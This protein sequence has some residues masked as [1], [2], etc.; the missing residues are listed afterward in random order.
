[1]QLKY[2]SDFC[3]SL[4]LNFINNIQPYGFLLVLDR[5]D[6]TI[7]QVSQNVGHHLGVPH[8][9]LVEQPLSSIVDEHQVAELEQKF[10]SGI[11]EK[12]PFTL[13][14]TVGGQRRQF[15]CLIHPKEELLL[16]EAEPQANEGAANHSFIAIYQ[17]VKFLMA[18]VERATTLQEV[19][20]I[21]L[22][23][24][25]RLSGFDRIMVYRFD[26]QWNGLVV[27][28]MLE[29]GMEPYLGLR[30]PASDIPQQAR[31]LY[32]KNAYRLIPD[33]NYEPVK[34]YPVI[35]PVLQTFADLSDCNLRAVATVHL[36]YL[37]N[38]GVTA[39]MSVR[40]IVNDE[41]WGLISC[42]HRTAKFLS[43][44]MC[45]V[46]ELLSGVISAKISSLQKQQDLG[47]RGAL[48]EIQ[49]ELVEQL[50][51]NGLVK[52]LTAG[53][54]NILSLLSADGVAIIQN[55]TV[56]TVGQT[57]DTHFLHDLIFW[58]QTKGISRV[59]ATDS[60]SEVYDDG[61]QHNEIASGMIVLPLNA[62]KG[63]FIIAFRPEVI[64]KFDWG[65]NPNERIQFE[66]D[67]K[68][69]HPRNSFKLWQQTVKHT[70]LPWHKEEVAIAEN[71]RH[72]LVEY[73]MKKAYV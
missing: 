71:L 57:P 53:S 16:I 17:Q 27:A 63:E 61:Y 68:T 23:E 73:T 41:L 37:G 29:E 35:N 69:Y 58:L 19:C 70:S 49:S 8:T 31:A 62:E 47:R 72:I 32:K 45:S 66:K 26:E 15:L 52:A 38:M 1:M 6:L 48:R 60:I 64:Q 44:E 12:L 67:N 14:F 43:Y 13:A 9:D 20:D 3:G 40:I 51:S 18:S 30:F 42:H 36:E 2:D 65:G 59:F 56:E 39:S 21:T 46:F 22:T 11:E 34:L 33:R 5:K 25:K 55:K 10:G 7:V 4:P 50:Y 24:L 28:E 54:S